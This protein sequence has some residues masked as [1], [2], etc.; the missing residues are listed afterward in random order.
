MPIPD[1]QT[2]MLPC[3]K[4]LADG[5]EYSNREAIDHLSAEFQL[6]EEEKKELLPSRKQARFDNR[7]HWV[8]VYLGMAQLLSSPRR[9]VM[10]ITS[11]GVEVL[12]TNPARID[13]NF[14]SQFPEF[15]EFRSRSRKKAE[16]RSPE[17]A[18]AELEQSP[19][20][21]M[22]TAYQTL[23]E[24]LAQELLQQVKS[25]SPFFFE[26]LVV[27]LLVRMGYGGSVRDAGQA[28]QKSSDEG[29]DGLIKEDRL[30]LDVIYI[31]A[32]RWE[33]TV[34]RPEIQKFAGALQGKRARKGVF[35]TT[36]G[37]SKEA[38]EYAQ[39]IDSKIILIDGTALA[40]YMI[41]FD[42]GVSKVNSYVIK[43]ID[44]EFFEEELGS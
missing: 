33:G 17:E 18:E 9:S 7:V 22:E 19:D 25:C 34:G 8:K 40:E 10:K 32:K 30:G 20:E 15:Q 39:S 16:L 4:F 5:G 43:K 28:L 44:Q 42:V 36:S 26:K 23:R 27:H 1:C 24:N 3:L 29:I 14:L 12:K 35:I 41:D 6:T 37:F 11:R 13:I 2:L 21:L 38:V 31:Q